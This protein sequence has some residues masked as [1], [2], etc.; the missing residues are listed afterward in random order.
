MNEVI[1]YYI[2]LGEER[3]MQ[4]GMQQK[5]ADAVEKMADYFLV[6]NPTL[7]REQAVEM[8]EGILRK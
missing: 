1:D 6:Q 5:E 2:N 8:A 4:K 3:G 7:T